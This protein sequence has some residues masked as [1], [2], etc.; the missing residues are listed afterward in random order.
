MEN[1]SFLDCSSPFCFLLICEFHHTFFRV[2]ENTTILCSL[3]LYFDEVVIIRRDFFY[4]MPAVLLSL[5]TSLDL[6]SS[7]VSVPYFILAVSMHRC[8]GKH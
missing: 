5:F 4:F 1:C 3:L 6:P 8:S 2:L 7:S